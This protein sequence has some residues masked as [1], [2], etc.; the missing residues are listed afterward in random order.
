MLLRSVR[1]FSGTNYLNLVRGHFFRSERV[2]PLKNYNHFGFYW[3]SWNNAFSKKP[4]GTKSAPPPP[5]TAL[6]LPKMKKCFECLK[7]LSH[8]ILFAISSRLREQFLTVLRNKV[9]RVSWTYELSKYAGRLKQIPGSYWIYWQ[10]IPSQC[11]VC[12]T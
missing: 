4:L 1:T 9:R 8:P 12:S 5:P 3:I 2:N 6:C 10:Y 7:S 11:P